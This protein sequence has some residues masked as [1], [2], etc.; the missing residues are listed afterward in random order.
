M[1]ARDNLLQEW[2]QFIV[3][4]A[5][6]G[7]LTGQPCA[8]SRIESIA[9]PR[10]GAL[11]IQAGLGS[12]KLLRA[13]ARDDAALLRQFVPWHFVGNPVTYMSGRSLRLEAGWPG[14]LAET[15][16]RLSDLGSHPRN[17]GRWIA[18]KNEYGATI[19]PGLNDRTPH[20]LIAGAT[21][22]GKS[23]AL[24][25][26][27]VQLSRDPRNQL[28]LLD[29][30]YGE[31]LK[32]VSHLPGVVGPVAIEGPTVRAALGWVCQVMRER[33]EVEDYAG[34]VIVVF[35]EFQELIGDPVVVDLL[36]KLTSQGRGCSVHLLMA[37]QHPTVGSFGTPET[38]RNLPGK[39]AMRVD[40]PDASRVA[41]GGRTPRADALLGG[42][43]C[44]AVA[45][46]AQHRIQGA[47]VDEKDYDTSG[48]WKFD[49]W[50]EPEE[51]GQELPVG[52]SRKILTPGEIG[53]SLIAAMEGEGRPALKRRIMDDGRNQPGSDRA[54]ALLS[55]GRKVVGYLEAHDVGLCYLDESGEEWEIG[56]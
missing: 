45:P 47:Y 20:Y 35:D 37:T 11:E 15:M 8:I 2:G 44:Y 30:K 14:R 43:D 6:Q 55:L 27:V 5:H 53:A 56:S 46:G 34:R 51:V 7:A 18:G 23:V 48:K 38:R 31:S 25:S 1:S 40:D 39:L 52:R 28:V 22:S 19:V 54:R 36:R 13:L 49:D 17:S 29:G 12:G 41:V 42:G 21:G 10:A 16:I 33:Y 3:K 24:R 32:R 9:G 4:A 26:A 50:P